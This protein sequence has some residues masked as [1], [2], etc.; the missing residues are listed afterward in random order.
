MTDSDA[1]HAPANCENCGTLLQ[2]HYCHECGQ[3][4]HSPTRHFGHALEEV[5]ESFWHLDGRVF[6]T[7][8]DLMVPGRV[9]R[10]YL[11][12]QRV[13]YIA[14]LRIFVI[15]SLLTFFVGKLVV[16]VDEPAVQFGGEGAAEIGRAQT[17]EEVKAVEARLLK[18]L[19]IE[20]DKARKVPGVNAALIATRAK[21]QGEAASR[22]VEIE[23]AAEKRGGQPVAG[24]PASTPATATTTPAAADKADPASGKTASKPAEEDPWR[25]NDRDWDEKTNPVDVPLM[26]GFVDRWVN[27]KIGRA[28]QNLE[29]MDDANHFVQAALGAVPTA[30]FLLMPVFAL[31]LKV[32]YLGSGRRYLEHLV[33]ALYSHAWLLLAILLMFVMNAFDDAAGDQGW[34]PVVTSLV[35]AAIWI[36]I[37]IYLFVMQHRVYGDHWALTAVRYFV[38]GSIYM[39]L[40]LF[41]VMFAVLAGI[42]A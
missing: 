5:F 32:L 36:W 34:V 10:N 7:L 24:T 8:R 11:A 39:F 13:R 14:P 42:V 22:I 33:V 21:I 40:V 2:G 4:V 17:V 37:P 12:G 19:E 38:I 9:A 28:K 35:D 18:K 15:V 29:H 30:L 6:R 26:P 23:Q 16:H 27:R 25:F 3:S 20:E 31:L 41:V 1:Q